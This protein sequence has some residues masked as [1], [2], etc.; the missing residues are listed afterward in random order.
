MKVDK[1]GYMSLNPEHF[2]QL[3]RGLV[4]FTKWRNS[5]QLQRLELEGADLR[6]KDLAGFRL[7][8]CN[9]KGAKL[10]YAILT[11]ANLTDSDLSGAQLNDAQL[12]GA[13][14]ERANC[15]GADFS[16]SN[17]IGANFSYAILTGAELY[18]VKHDS[19]T[20]F[21]FVAVD[22]ISLFRFENQ[23]KKNLPDFYGTAIDNARMSP[24]LRTLVKQHLRRK[25]WQDWV[26]DGSNPGRRCL[27]WTGTRWWIISDYGTSTTRIVE[28]FIVTTAL[29]TYS[30]F[31]LSQI[32][33]DSFHGISTH[34]D[35]SVTQSMQLHRCFY[36][37]IVT[38]TTLG[39][40][41][42]LPSAN[43]WLSHVAVECQVMVGYFLLAALVTRM[44]ILFTS[45][46]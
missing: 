11:N 46:E 23:T 22:G 44:G 31:F 13:N 35:D 28:W 4:E 38:M 10:N 6:S 9:L 37:S 30:Y 21:R 34:N 26:R 2:N 36:F 40:G 1:V 19:N 24:E 16:F 8:R 45:I 42:V 14:L 3:S 32:Q 33:P 20:Q 18:N 12:D 7:N 27:R 43:S 5:N 29:F 17:L 39:F 25:I 41:D 15:S